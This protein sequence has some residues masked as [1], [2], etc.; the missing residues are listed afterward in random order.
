MMKILTT[1]C[2][3]VAWSIAP[4]GAS[5]QLA[6]GTELPTLQAKTLAGAEMNLPKDS[7]GRGA[8]LV[9]GFS[10]ASADVTRPWLE[11]CRTT[12]APKPAATR[13][14]C[15]DVRMLA[16]VPWLLRGLVERGMRSGLPADLQKTV[17]LIYSDND[18]WRKRLGVADAN[19]AYV[20][21]CDKDGIVRATTKGPHAQKELERLLGLIQG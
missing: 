2:L 20:V 8:L 15:Y 17:L 11:A 4:A 14:T 1:V 18:A 16:E 19:S 12:A 10:R 21:A 6:V 7:K 3:A 5:P 13:T 9:V